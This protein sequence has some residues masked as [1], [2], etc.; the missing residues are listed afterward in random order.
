MEKR[1]KFSNI[2]DECDEEDLLLYLED[3]GTGIGD[4]VIENFDEVAHSAVVVVKNSEG[5]A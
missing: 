1:L 3:K 5:I 4:V 2:P